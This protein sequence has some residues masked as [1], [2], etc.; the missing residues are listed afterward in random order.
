[1]KEGYMWSA[2]LKSDMPLAG[3]DMNNNN[4]NLVSK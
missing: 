1:M 4:N 2:G 3:H